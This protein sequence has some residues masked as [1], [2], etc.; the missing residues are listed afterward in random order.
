MGEKTE[1]LLVPLLRALWVLA[2]GACAFGLTVLVP[3]IG[4]GIGIVLFGALLVR[5]RM[6][7]Y[8]WFT[9]GFA[10]W[11]AVF[12]VLAVVAALTDSP[13]SGVATGAGDSADGGADTVTIATVGSYHPFD[14]INDEGEIDGLEP[15]LGDE[16]CRRADLDCEWVIDDW[17]DMIPDLV[18]GD[19]D[20]IFS[21]MSITAEREELIDFTAAYYPPTPS[22]YVVRAGEGD[23]AVQGTIGAAVNTI[24]SD[25]FTGLGRPF[26]E[27]DE[28]TGTTSSVDALLDGTVDAVLVDHGYAVEKLSKYEGQLAIVGPSVLL[29]RGL[30]IGVR[31]G[32]ELKPKLDEALA[33][34]K[35]DGTVNTLILKW[36][37]A[38]ASTFE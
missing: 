26:V 3:P 2:G 30:G 22:V 1:R 18:A 35:A 6:G 31:K 23:E 15:E 19:F 17:V 10:V 34:M 37:G 13:S 20:A 11:C 14:F 5:R 8:G 16:L 38:D 12:G 7:A 29:D 27:L 4:L 28:S 36:V 32:S 24:Y 33:S 9:V 21:G 25:Y